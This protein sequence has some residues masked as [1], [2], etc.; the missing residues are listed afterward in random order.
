MH[1]KIIYIN[2]FKCSHCLTEW[3]IRWDDNCGDECPKCN[4]ISH[5]P[6]ESDM[7]VIKSGVNSMVLTKEDYSCLSPLLC[8]STTTKDKIFTK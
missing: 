3:L 5:D 4:E 7:L 6:V 1:K 8:P 2:T